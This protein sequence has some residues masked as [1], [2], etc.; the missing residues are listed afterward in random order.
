MHLGIKDGGDG[1]P[2]WNRQAVTA[3]VDEVNRREQQVAERNP[4]VVVLPG[5][6]VCYGCEVME[7][8]YGI[9]C[10][11]S[12]TRTRYVVDGEI[13]PRAEDAVGS[14]LEVEGLRNRAPAEL[15]EQVRAKEKASAGVAASS[16][17]GPAAPPPPGAGA[18]TPPTTL[19]PHPGRDDSRRG[20]LRGLFGR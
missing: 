9:K 5:R 18:P 11:A 17:A 12:L 15:H 20:G 6:L 19:P 7:F 13:E 3:H 10:T 2:C 1:V 4:D 8:D 14:L 16:G